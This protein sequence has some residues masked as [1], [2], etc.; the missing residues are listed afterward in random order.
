[1]LR[2]MVLKKAMKKFMRCVS[3]GSVL[4]FLLIY[5]IEVISMQKAKKS[6][7]FQF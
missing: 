4:D 7:L 3:R 1:M 6:E 5:S 2:Q